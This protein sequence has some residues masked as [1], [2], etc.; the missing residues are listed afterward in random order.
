MSIHLMTRAFLSMIDTPVGG[1]SASSSW[2][3][4]S[5]EC[6]ENSLGSEQPSPP[7]LRSANESVSMELAPERKFVRPRRSIVS[8]PSPQKSK[9][10]SCSDNAAEQRRLKSDWERRNS[11]N[12]LLGAGGGDARLHGSFSSSCLLE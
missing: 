11:P 12:R 9:N 6:W 1:C 3:S 2:N 7:T 8:T 10:C 4:P 5:P